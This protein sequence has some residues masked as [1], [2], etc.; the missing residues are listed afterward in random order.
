M[1]FHETVIIW[2]VAAFENERIEL[3]DGNGR[4]FQELF[5]R[6]IDG[7]QLLQGEAVVVFVAVV[8]ELL[9]VD[10]AL[11]LLDGHVFEAE[12]HLSQL[13]RVLSL[14][15]EVVVEIEE[16]N[17]VVEKH[18][19]VGMVL[20]PDLVRGGWGCEIRGCQLVDR[21][22]LVVLRRLDVVLAEQPAVF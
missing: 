2:N 12:F 3:G 17:V 6:G 14:K 5:A 7:V 4:V 22:E 13:V 21:F 10:N 16:V 8:A 11:Q 1:D 19:A 18:D 20:L 9:D 15:D